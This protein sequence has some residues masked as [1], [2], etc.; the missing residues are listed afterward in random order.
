MRLSYWLFLFSG[1][2]PLH[3]P[4]P[5]TGAERRLV[6]LCAVLACASTIQ[7]STWISTPW[8]TSSSRISTTVGAINFVGH[9]HED[10]LPGDVAEPDALFPVRHDDRVFRR[11]LR[12]ARAHASPACSSSSSAAS[13][14][15]S[16][17]SRQG[18]IRCSGSTCS[19]SSGTRGSTSWSCRPWAWCP[20]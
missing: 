6:R 12:A 11:A 4:L 10:A 3:E 9:D 5:R 18:G 8:P 13:A 20:R 1:T 19:G 7:G 15:T 16:S 2:L 14:C 17:T